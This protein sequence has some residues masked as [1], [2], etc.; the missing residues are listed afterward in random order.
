M[1]KPCSLADI[2]G[3]IQSIRRK[4]ACAEGQRK[5][6]L[7]TKFRRELT[8]WQERELRAMGAEESKSDEPGP[9]VA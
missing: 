6:H 8:N 4:I 1:A 7:V 5:W 9:A 2:R 3:R